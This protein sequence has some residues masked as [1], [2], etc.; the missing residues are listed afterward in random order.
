M[1]AQGLVKVGFV[2][3]SHQALQSQSPRWQEEEANQLRREGRARRRDHEVRAGRSRRRQD[4]GRAVDVDAAAALPKE[5]GALADPDG[6]RHVEDG[7]GQVRRDR[8]WPCLVEGHRHRGRVR[9]IHL[10]KVDV[11]CRPPPEIRPRR[12][13]Q[14]QDADGFGLL[15]A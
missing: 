5:H 15:S 12:Q 6:R 13:V 10:D 9:D 11:S 8:R 7:E 4:V 3:D 1:W 14:V 2:A